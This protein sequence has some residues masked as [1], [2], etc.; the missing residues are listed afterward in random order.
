MNAQTYSTRS[1]ALR[2]A[3]RTFG[4]TATE[5]KT[6]EVK[7][8]EGR[9]VFDAIAKKA[10]KPT[11][12]KAKAKPAKAAQTVDRNPKMKGKTWG[13]GVVQNRSKVVGPVAI[14]W[15]LCI[16]MKGARRKD[17]IAA[18]MK[19]GVTFNTAR[20]Q[21]QYWYAANNGR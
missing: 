13:P 19:Q 18:A 7:Q 10:A 14:V 4:A 5:G 8:K 11:K 3:R 20:S 1:T 17:V 15:D 2:A 16:K 6:F 21:Y 12:T 9:Y